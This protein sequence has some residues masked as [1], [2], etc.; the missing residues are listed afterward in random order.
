[1]PMSIYFVFRNVRQ[2]FLLFLLLI[3]G[4]TA[5]FSAP[6]ATAVEPT[7][8][9]L[10]V[11]VDILKDQIKKL[12]VQTPVASSQGDPEV[13]RAAVDA[14][15]KSFEY[16]S[17]IMDSN[18]NV[19]RGQ[20]FASSVVLFLVVIIVFS[21]ILFAG[22]QLWK[23]VAVAGVQNSSDLELSAAK[24][25]VTS[26]VVGVTVLVISLAFLYIYTKEIY[27]IRTL[28][29]SLQQAAGTASK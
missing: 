11:Q 28:D 2:S 5:S 26:S 23:S 10:Q 18:I 15:R 8:E 14:Q 27:V 25:R 12:Q 22:F 24:V 19:L 16:T 1:M 20:Q 13:R 7:C 6:P 17:A 9:Q 29:T 21:G 4:S 3:L